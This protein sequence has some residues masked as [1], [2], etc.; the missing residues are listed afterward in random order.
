M[1]ARCHLGAQDGRGIS[2][3]RGNHDQAG[4][5]GYN[6]SAQSAHAVDSGL[7][8][9]AGIQSTTTAEKR[10]LHVKK[11]G[12]PAGGAGKSPGC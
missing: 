5:Y 12:M 2:G 4:A 10:Y 8:N 3:K 11:R 6:C 1:A 9:A 7:V